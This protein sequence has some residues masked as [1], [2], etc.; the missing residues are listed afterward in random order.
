[1]EHAQEVLLFFL[2]ESDKID[3]TPISEVPILPK[4]FGKKFFLKLIFQ[5]KDHPKFIKPKLKPK[6]K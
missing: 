3:L 1:M 2:F 4:L 5:N 6:P